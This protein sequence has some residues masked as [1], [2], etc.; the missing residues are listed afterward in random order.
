MRSRIRG[1]RYQIPA[2]IPV[3]VENALTFSEIEDGA[4]FPR[5]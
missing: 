1:V 3:Y 4:L 5:F 2:R